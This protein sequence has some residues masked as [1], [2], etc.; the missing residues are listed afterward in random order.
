MGIEPGEAERVA[1]VVAGLLPAALVPTFD[2]R[3]TRS[4]RLFDEY[5][6]RLTLAVVRQAKLEEA[7]GAWGTVEE[8]VTRAGLAPRSAVVPVDWMLRRLAARNA[9]EMRD[10]RFRAS[11]TVPALDAGEVRDA[12]QRHDPAALPSY[13]LA[14]TAA[15]AYPAFLQGAKSGEELLLAPARLA[16]WNGYFSNEHTLYAVN[17]RVGAF[18]LAAW[19]SAGSHTILELGAGMGSGTTAALEALGRAARLGDVEAYRATD[20]VPTFLRYA[21]RRVRETLSA[22]PNVTFGGLDM[23]KPFAAQGVEA[24]TLSVVYAVNTLHVAHDL[25]MTLGEVRQALRPG[26][27]LIMCECVRPRPGQTLYPEFVFNMLATFRAPRLHP[28]YRPNGG[29]LTPEQWRRALAESGFRDVRM[30]PDIERLRDLV[31]EF[32]V[33]AIAGTRP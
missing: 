16:L 22:A 17:N 28:A 21:E 31:P 8:V 30:L 15:R 23:N 1:A 11:P 24:G 6:S 4:D 13:T 29:F 14:E 7:L 12:Q 33:G 3:F 19:L 9:V 20:V 32:S 18:A 26:G 25:A 2:A 5:V 27:Q 10:G